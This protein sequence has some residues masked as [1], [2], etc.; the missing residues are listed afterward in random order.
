MSDGLRFEATERGLVFRDPLPV[1]S[2]L[3]SFG[4][5]RVGAVPSVQ[6]IAP[7]G[8]A[9]F[10]A[11]VAV[12]SPR[13]KRDLVA[14]AG[15]V[16]VSPRFRGDVHATCRWVHVDAE[17]TFARILQS[18]CPTD[19]VPAIHRHALIED[20]AVIGA[21]CAIGGRHAMGGCSLGRGCVIEPGAVVYEMYS[22]ATVCASG[23]ALCL[24]DPDSAG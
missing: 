2:W 3:D 23:P 17:E 8:C 9:S 11:F 24:V 4:G 20:G 13:A 12:F 6:R 21:D 10:D 5:E 1:A 19:A 15:V 14:T 7:P 16:L 22:W 18:L